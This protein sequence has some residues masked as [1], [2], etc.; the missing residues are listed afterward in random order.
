VLH[1]ILQRWCTGFCSAFL[2]WFASGTWLIGDGLD[3][4]LKISVSDLQVM[5]HGDS[6]CV[7]EPGC[8]NVNRVLFR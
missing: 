8:E 7:P 5:L 4:L 3:G 1:R 6:W 2:L